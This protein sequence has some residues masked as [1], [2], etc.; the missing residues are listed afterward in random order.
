MGTNQQKVISLQLQ[1]TKRQPVWISNIYSR[2]QVHQLR[3][4]EQGIV[5]GT[6]TALVDNPCLTTRQ[7]AGNLTNTIGYR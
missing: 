2:Q 3:A 5:I 7:W 4:Q 1:K 6:T